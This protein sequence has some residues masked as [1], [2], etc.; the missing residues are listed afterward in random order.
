MKHFTQQLKVFIFVMLSTTSLYA[1]TEYCVP[2]YSG[3]AVNEPAEPITL[4][5]FG[6]AEGAP[7]AINKN[8]PTE[9]SV[10]TLR[11]ENFSNISMDVTRG[12]TYT[13]LV[14]ANTN[15]NNTN[16]ITIYFDWNGDGTF[17]NATPASEAAQQQLTGQPEKHQHT[18]AIVNSTG[19]DTKEMIHTVTIPNDAVLGS[20][21]MRIVKNLNAPASHPCTNPFFPR[22]QVEDYTLNIVEASTVHEV[23]VATQNSVPATILTASGTLQLVANVLPTASAS[24]NV[25][26]TVVS[27][28]NTVTVNA[29]G[30]VTA[31][32]N[33]GTA[34][35]R[36]TSVED[37]TK[38]DE[39][40][41][42]I[43]VPQE[44]ATLD[45]TENFE[46]SNDWTYVNQEGRTTRWTI[47]NAV[48][49]GTGSKAL[50]V[51]NDNGV[52]NST[53]HSIQL[54]VH[55]YR[56]IEIPAGTTNAQLSFDWKSEGDFYDG[57]WGYQVYNFM[58][59]WIVPASYTPVGG[60]LVSDAGDHI[61]I[62]GNH[63]GGNFLEQPDFTTYTNN[64][65]NLSAY[66]GQTVRLVFSWKNING[67]GGTPAAI[68]N[69][70]LVIPVVTVTGVQITTQGNVTPEITEENGTLQLTAT[71]LPL[72]VNQEVTWS[73]VSGEEYGTID[74][75]GLVTAVANGTIV[76]RATSDEDTTKFAE[77][78]ITVAI[79]EDP[80]PAECEAQTTFFYNF[81]DFTTF[82][83][84]C[85]AVS[86]LPMAMMAGVSGTVNK[87]VQLYSFEFGNQDIY[88]VSP[89][90]STIDGQHV[91][92]F[93]VADAASGTMIQ[94]GTMASQTDFSGFTPVGAPFTPTVGNHIS[95]VV[96]AVAT[97]K[98]V[99]IRF[100][101]NGVHKSINLDNIEWKQQSL[102]TGDFDKPEVK[103][104]PNPTNDRV[105]I[106][107][108]MN[109]ENITVYNQLGQI[110]KS[111][112]AQEIDLSG[113]ASGVYYLNI[114]FTNGLLSKEKVIKK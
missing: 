81:D 78:T 111:Q 102:S 11:Y 59:V 19:I 50:Y 73:V 51:S 31:L 66:A 35:I 30:L 71:V 90:T 110:I 86:Q 67:S 20:I 87:T 101:P 1:Q 93:D 61:K 21:R 46:T 82:P 41:I 7:D 33:N 91:L 92:A 95:P 84:Q 5:Q 38:F 55:A 23:T 54:M 65:L 32:T 27:G 28:T 44:P 103:V 80:I 63:Q 10:A 26:W 37:T 22:G 43:A 29:N 62:Q 104:Y 16:Y 18:T 8:S 109:I 17:S 74:E 94:I 77:I 105:F 97:H 75:N 85:W 112:T 9:V 114:Q 76:I 14:K 49:N 79:N 56:D 36:A 53:D 70:A 45:Y 58:E 13:L 99:A 40:E 15:G 69:V 48:H 47:G 39:I 68:D 42:N 96:P 6:V 89:E 106:D 100:I 60:S 12:E 108:E 34:V 57:G 52:T 25:T 107:S 88:I 2:T 4:V 64:N 24:Q 3:W 98:Y 72:T 113:A 83:E